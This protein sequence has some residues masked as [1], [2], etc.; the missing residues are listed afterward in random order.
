MMKALYALLVASAPLLGFAQTPDLP[1]LAYGPAPR[2]RMDVYLPAR[3]D[4]APVLLVVHGGAWMIGNKALPQVVEQKFAHW[5]RDRGFILVSVNYRLVPEADPPTQAADVARALATVQQRAQ[6]WG[7]D[8][9]RVV[10]MGHSAGAHLVALLSARPALA[11]A[12]GAAPWRGTVVLDSAAL[13]T[14]GLMQ[15]PHL[16]FYD[17]AF[18]ADPEVW[19]SA[20]PTAQLSRGALPMLLVCSSQRRDDPCAQ[21]RAFA[22]KTI[23]SG[24]RAEVLPQDLSHA[25]IN[26]ELGRPGAYTAAVDAFIASVGIAR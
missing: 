5:V 8:P 21:S 25:Q 17:R 6:S 13:D 15:R 1:D 2:Q 9:S 7:G 16:R 24:G 18:G 19:R 22:N 23:A 4:R 10:L 3:A 11:A 14:A 20:S 12:Q 26:A